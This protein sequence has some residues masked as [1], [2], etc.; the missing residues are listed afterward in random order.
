MN[1][2]KLRTFISVL[3][4]LLL[5][6]TCGFAENGIRI[7]GQIG[8]DGVVL[9]GGAW[10]LTLN[11]ENHSEKTSTDISASILQRISMTIMMKCAYP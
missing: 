11:I 2:K 8:F 5:F 1:T 4:L 6:T 7:D 9:Q 10:R 3:I